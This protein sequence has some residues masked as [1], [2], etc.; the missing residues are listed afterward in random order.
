MQR[1][2]S[3]TSKNVLSFGR[4]ANSKPVCRVSPS[5][6][7]QN[8][9][10][11]ASES[12][13]EYVTSVMERESQHPS[14]LPEDSLK[15]HSFNPN[16]S[17]HTA[18]MTEKNIAQPHSATSTRM[19]MSDR[20]SREHLMEMDKLAYL[21]G[22]DTPRSLAAEV[23]EEQ[24]GIA[25]PTWEQRHKILLLEERFYDSIT[26][27]RTVASRRITPHKICEFANEL[28]F[29]FENCCCIDF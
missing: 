17:R 10:K 20:G 18:C 13:T 19:L 24:L 4:I 7:L 12:L 28:Y 29:D 9:A 25:N 22:L 21:T 11:I 23:V 26:T 8:L 16:D 6:K 27:K 1:A 14:E 5:E 15:E 3:V 2:E